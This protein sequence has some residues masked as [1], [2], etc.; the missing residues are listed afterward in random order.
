MNKYNPDSR[1]FDN[2]LVILDSI[3][4]AS[5]TSGALIVEGGLSTKDTY[6]TGHV[7]INN[8]KITPNLED[9]LNERQVELTPSESWVDIGNFTFRNSLT[10]AFKA[11]MFVTRQSPAQSSLWTLSGVYDNTAWKYQSMFTGD[12]MSDIDFRLIDNENTG[13]VQYMNNGT[14]ITMRYT[15]TTNADIGSDPTNSENILL[16][17]AGSFV[18]GG[19][20]YGGTDGTVNYSSELKYLNNRLTVGTSSN[21]LIESDATF[22]NFSNGGALTVMGDTSIAKDLI[23]G[24]RLG[25]GTTSPEYQLDV[26]GDMK[27]SGGLTLGNLTLNNLSYTSNIFTLGN[28]FG[29][30]T[31][32][33]GIGTTSPREVLD[34]RGNLNIGG[35]TTANYITFSGT[36]SDNG[37]SVIEGFTSGTPHT[38]IGERIYEA[39]T[40]RSELILAKFNDPS[41][42]TGPDRIRLL[43]GEIGFDL[44]TSTV[45]ANASFES[46][47]T[48]TTTRAMTILNNGN[49]GISTSSP[50]ALLDLGQNDSLRK[51]VLQSFVS[52]NDHQFVGFG[53]SAGN[54]RY[55][56]PGSTNAYVHYFE[57][58]INSSSSKRIMIM[59]GDG[60]VGIGFDNPNSITATLDVNGSVTVRE[61]LKITSN[62]PTINE[63]ALDVGDRSGLK[64]RL[65]VFA[66]N[67]Q[68]KVLHFES[69]SG[70]TAALVLSRYDTNMYFSQYVTGGSYTIS[71]TNNLGSTR[72]SYGTPFFVITSTGNIGMGT[73]APLSKLHVAGD[74]SLTSFG[75]WRIGDT[76]GNL[77][78]FYNNTLIAYLNKNG[79]TGGSLNNFT[80]QHRCVLHDEYT[81]DMIGLI[82]CADSNEYVNMSNGTV[83]GKSAMTITESLPVVRLSTSSQ[84]KTCFGVIAGL[85]EQRQDTFGTI[86]TPF[87]KESGD[88]RV[89]VNSVGEGGIWVTDQTG[90][91]SSGDYMTTASIPGYATK[92]NGEYLTNYTVAK[93]TRDCDF[94]NPQTP[95]Y[96][97]KRDINGQNVLDNN[98]R[99]IWEQDVGPSGEPL[100]EDSYRMR[101]LRPDGTVV[102]KSEYEMA[103]QNG[104]EVYRAAFIGCT[105]H[106]G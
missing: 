4:K 50:T 57:G 106:C 77:G 76:S 95:K 15:A 45:N 18:Q 83:R 40:E 8:V 36:L 39:G 104:E 60:L 12:N 23:I 70:G 11:T 63:V 88:N 72:G 64:N 35:S 91:L 103:I 98:G 44:Y 38:Y 79:T 102:S 97:I 51:L 3:T 53:V 24:N 22:Q 71:F 75:D 32:R 66:T 78:F 5:A 34:V 65:T 48:L 17:T 42:P 84:S 81:E 13:Q 67:N 21:V 26:V 93:I 6:V 33:V 69:N 87:L 52:G 101:Y 14:I 92:Q 55:Q 56:I 49:V 9:I 2:Q 41:S 59:R 86:V 68:D 100:F 96:I 74:I 90:L 82:V 61:G 16:T 10:R 28:V 31:G 62:D 58:G 25:I 29:T 30:S 7:A 89:Y 54:I 105:Y 73:T 46:V 85:E 37:S 94:T 43:A 19:L 20:L 99:L 80:G 1:I 27:I 47:G